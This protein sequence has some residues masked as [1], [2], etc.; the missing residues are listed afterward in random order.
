MLQPDK[1]PTITN[2]VTGVTKDLRLTACTRHLGLAE[3][4][5]KDDNRANASHSRDSKK[6]SSIVHNLSALRV[7]THDDLGIGT[8]RQSSADV[9]G[10]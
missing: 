6:G 3:R 8:A 10:P 2:I 1:N 5:S 9:R 4:I 7:S